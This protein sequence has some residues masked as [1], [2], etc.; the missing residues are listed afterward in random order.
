MTL[1]T[2][3]AD[4]FRFR[5]ALVFLVGGL[6][7]MLWAWGS[8]VYRTSA[9]APPMTAVAVDDAETPESREDATSVTR[10]LQTGLALLPVIV[11]GGVLLVWFSRRPRK[12]AVPRREGAPSTGDTIR[13]DYI[14]GDDDGVEHDGT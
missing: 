5:A 12:A 11:G 7:L 14:C 9:S 2:H 13:G 1:G 8:W 10:L 6:L 3:G 4:S